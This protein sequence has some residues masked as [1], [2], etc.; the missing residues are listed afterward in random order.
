MP[1]NYSV[2][3][4]SVCMDGYAFTKG[5]PLEAYE[6]YLGQPNRCNVP[7]LRAPYGHRN[8]IAYLFDEHGIVL[9]EH[10]ATRLIQAVYFILIPAGSRYKTDKAFSGGLSV[11]NTP[12]RAGMRFDEFGSRCEFDFTAHLGHAWFLDSDC[13][14]IQFEVK[15]TRGRKGLERGLVQYICVGFRGAHRTG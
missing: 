2:D 3:L 14:S 10:H 1:N 15:S 5:E 6:A 11:L 9:T 4:S 12:V 7:K 13:I 8:N